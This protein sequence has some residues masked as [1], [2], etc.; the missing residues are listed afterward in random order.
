MPEVAHPGHVE[1]EGRE[2]VV[3]DLDGHDADVA[4]A[5]E[6]IHEDHQCQ[7]EHGWVLTQ[8][9]SQSYSNLSTT[10]ELERMKTANLNMRAMK[11]K[12]F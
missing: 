4:D 11:K 7:I 5:Y 8:L 12:R 9:S 6:E 2:I 3:E 1:P 10:S